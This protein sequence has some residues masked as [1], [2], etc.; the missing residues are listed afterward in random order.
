MPIYLFKSEEQL[1]QEDLRIREEQLKKFLGE[2]TP[3]YAKAVH[4]RDWATHYT[5]A[6]GVG[7]KIWLEAQQQERQRLAVQ[8]QIEIANERARANAERKRQLV[9]A[10]QKAIQQR[11]LQQQALRTGKTI[12]QIK[13]QRKATTQKQVSTITSAETIRTSGKEYTRLGYQKELARLGK[14][15]TSGKAVSTLRKGRKRI[16]IEKYT[17]VK[18]IYRDPTKEGFII[19]DKTG[20]RFIEPTAPPRSFVD[21]GGTSSNVLFQGFADVKVDLGL[22]PKPTYKIK[23]SKDVTREATIKIPSP[24]FPEEALPSKPLSVEKREGGFLSKTYEKQETELLRGGRSLSLSA[25][26]FGLGLGLSAVSGAKFTEDLFLDPIGTTKRVVTSIPQIPSQIPVVLATAKARPSLATGYLV[27][28]GL[29]AVAL[30]KALIPFRRIKITK[31]LRKVRTPQFIEK[32]M[33][34][35][36]RGKEFK[37]STYNIFGEYK[38]PRIEKLTTPFRESLGFKPIKVK[39][40]P[41]KKFS[42]KTIDYALDK[43]PFDVSLVKE[44]KRS[45]DIFKIEGYSKLINPQ[46]DI[47]KLTKIEKFTLSKLKPLVSEKFLGKLFKR[48]SDISLSDI[49]V[50]KLARAKPSI[51]SLSLKT[52]EAG[53]LRE[54]SKAITETKPFLET[55]TTRIFTSET[56][57]KDVTKPFAR[58]TGKTP[59][60]KGVIYQLKYP[61]ILDT[62][63]SVKFITPASIKKT[64]L[65]KTFQALKTKQVFET[66]KPIVKIPEVKTTIKSISPTKIKTPT[67]LSQVK[68]KTTLKDKSIFGDLGVIKTRFDIKQQPQVKEITKIKQQPKIKTISKLKQLSK[69][70]TISKI[71]QVS[72][73]KQLSKLKQIQKLKQIPKLKLLTKSKTKVSPFPTPVKIPK[74]PKVITPVPSLLFGTPKGKETR[75]RYVT[76]IRRFGKWKPI[77]KLPSLSKAFALGKGRVSKTLAASFKVT[78]IPKIS[79]RLPRGFYRSKKEKGVFIEKIGRRLKKGT[80]EIPEI[81]LFKKLKKKR[82]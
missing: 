1:Q 66:P 44:G 72:K 82:G 68:V 7:S 4:G 21:M 20:S 23:E 47:S 29:Q 55:P 74:P 9:E 45:A 3:E 12:Q 62:K 31:A 22:P 81:Q 80:K 40:L 64:P 33:S 63:T 16:R 36:S 76:S 50:T 38:P 49:E 24:K 67:L 43:K 15:K 52:K 54:L 10:K 26:E 8:R 32:Q 34:V 39:Y 73:L 18:P 5:Q 60:L 57:F 58:A 79:G 75:G 46:T 61:I 42:I 13:Q 51:K 53:R 69:L 25:R 71:K 27:G 19:S 48:G 41:P 6:G 37:L 70:K 17:P 30:G 28:E 14:F 2:G 56:Y 35:I 77:G 78:G 11:Q 59:K 65:T